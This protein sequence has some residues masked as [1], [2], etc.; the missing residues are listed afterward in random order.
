MTSY[1]TVRTITRRLEFDAGHRVLGHEGK[2]AN[3]HGHRYAVEVTF[4]AAL[5]HLD[6]VIDFGTVKE[7]LGKWIDE[8]WDH[9]LILNQVDPMNKLFIGIGRSVEINGVRVPVESIFGNKAPYI[10]KGGRNP[11]AE[12]MAQELY[13]VCVELLPGITVS[14]VR[15]YETPNCW[16]D[17]IPTDQPN[18]P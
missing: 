2:C 5:D 16:A 15:I 8:H 11:T 4:S 14:A 6:R 13:Y 17:Y 12:A 3:L 1:R 7:V 10:M 9:N 18:P